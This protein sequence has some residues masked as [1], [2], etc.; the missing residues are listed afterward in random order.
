MEGRVKVIYGRKEAGGGH[1][2]GQ[3]SI[4]KVFRVESGPKSLK[5]YRLKVSFCIK[6]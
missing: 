3:R 1:V 4:M 6:F 2:I 5:V